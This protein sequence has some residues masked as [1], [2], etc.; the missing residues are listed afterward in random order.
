M[1]LILVNFPRR[2]LS[3]KLDVNAWHCSFIS[4][5]CASAFWQLN[6]CSCLFRSP[7]DMCA[8]IIHECHVG[9]AFRTVWNNTESHWGLCCLAPVI[10]PI[11]IKLR[12]GGVVSE[13]FLLLAIIQG[14][15]R[16]VCRMVYKYSSSAQLVIHIPQFNWWFMHNIL[17]KTWLSCGQ[18]FNMK[19][20]SIMLYMDNP[21]SGSPFQVPF[22]RLYIL[23]IHSCLPLEN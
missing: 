6:I 5:S 22:A 23:E 19:V 11:R 1:L 20:V 15:G 9:Y 21:I 3:M 10:M 12:E 7:I 4:S 14:D 17:Y 13:V 8:V 18:F 16:E 2:A